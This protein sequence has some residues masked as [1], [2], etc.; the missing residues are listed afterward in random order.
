MLRRDTATI[1]CFIPSFVQTARCSATS[2]S[3]AA[4]GSNQNCPT[5]AM[6]RPLL[7]FT[8][9]LASRLRLAALPLPSHTQLHLHSHLGHKHALPAV[10][11]MQTRGMKVR[12][13][14][15]RMCDGCSVVKRKGRIYIICAK[16]PKHKQVCIFLCHHT[17]SLLY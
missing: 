9:P 8:R 16:N 10:G 3:S 2:T 7:A 4:N 12:S 17:I 14:V 6:L 1:S 11:Q 13:S 15:K 5:G